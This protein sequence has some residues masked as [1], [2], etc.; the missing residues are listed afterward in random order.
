[1]PAGILSRFHHWR[2]FIRAGARKNQMKM[3][4]FKCHAPIR[5]GRH[6]AI[7]ARPWVGLSFHHKILLMKIQIYPWYEI[8]ILPLQTVKFLLSYNHTK[9][10]RY[11]RCLPWKLSNISEICKAWSFYITRD[12]Q[13]MNLLFCASSIHSNEKGGSSRPLTISLN[14][15]LA[16]NRTLWHQKCQDP[17]TWILTPETR[18]LFL[19]FAPLLAQPQPP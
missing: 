7:A 3:L 2:V 16:A 17:N 4:E 8:T 6:V 1:M 5:R 11:Y 9:I 14:P 10:Y 12:P 18:D 13:C 19:W 15:L